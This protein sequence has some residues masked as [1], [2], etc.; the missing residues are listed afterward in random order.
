MIFLKM[1][2]GNSFFNLG[3]FSLR[4]VVDKPVYKTAITHVHSVMHNYLC[5]TVYLGVFIK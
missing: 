2:Y 4:S 3:E 1:D 5:D